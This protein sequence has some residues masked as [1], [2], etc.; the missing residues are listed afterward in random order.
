MENI[1]C[2]PQT[3]LIVRHSSTNFAC[4]HEEQ[5]W[6]L[7]QFYSAVRICAVYQKHRLCVPLCK[8]GVYFC[9]FCAFSCEEEEQ[10]GYVLAGMCC[11]AVLRKPR[12][13]YF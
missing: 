10:F 3:Q 1:P 2:A 9:V 5:L 4:L 7:D 6:L 13:L 8:Y 11:V 12:S